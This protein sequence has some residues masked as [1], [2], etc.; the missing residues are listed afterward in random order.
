MVPV[1]VLPTTLGS[2]T[3]E[4]P[5]IL[6]SGPP[7]ASADQIRHAF[8]LG[9]GGAVIKTITP[10]GMVIED[11]SP[12]FAA[13]KDQDSHLL[14]FENI[15]LL[16]KKSVS[17]WLDEIP[18]IR[19]EFPKKILIASIMAGMDP[20]EWQHLAS[21]VAF[22]G[23]Q[24]IELNFSCPHGMPERG[25]GAAIGGDA[26]LVRTLTGYVRDAISIP[27]IVKLTPNVTDI[28][29]IAQAAVEGGADM[30]S[31][32]NTVQSLMSVDIETFEPAPSVAG[33]STYGG[34][35]GP[36]VK[37]IGLRVV[38]QIA[39]STNVPV[40]GIGGVSSFEDATEYILV[41]ASAVQVCTA[42]M[43]GGA[44]IIREMLA[45][46]SGYLQRKGYRS[47]DEIRGKALPH[48]TSHES[49]D[50]KNRL[51]PVIDVKTCKICG[52]CV[53]SCRDG[54]Y[55]ALILTREG[56][57]LD[58]DRCDT[59]SLCSLVCPTGSIRMKLSQP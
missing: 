56:V 24:A 20:K 38:S 48:L 18:K 11:V 8:S 34:Y 46:L 25:L 53:I 21:Q 27:L 43:W 23:V 9:W 10:D 36:G 15:E 37:P 31:A 49:L 7:T 22:A 30:I 4:N 41:G 35:S 51:I 59:C 47:P 40:I 13:W 5:F 3:L 19:K 6:A 54:G 17:Y 12:R 50:R 33:Y 52:Q 42:V 32:I 58:P 1:P 14:G 55:Q 26:D 45:G 29:P 2:L 39:R 28:V 57:I 16:S 44:G